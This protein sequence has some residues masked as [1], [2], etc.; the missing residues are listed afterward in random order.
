MAHDNQGFPEL[1]YFTSPYYT[2]MQRSFV[3]GLKWMFFD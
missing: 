1:G 2:G 3:F